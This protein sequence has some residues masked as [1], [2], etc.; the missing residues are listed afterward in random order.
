M[1]PRLHLL[2]AA[3]LFSTGGAAIKATSLT[4][5]QRA[6]FR[7]A[8]AAAALVVLLPAAR[9]AWPGP[10]ALL[11]AVAYAATMVTFVL[12]NSYGTAASAIFLQSVAPL[13]LLAL[14]PWLL[15]EPVTRRDLAFMAA[16]ACGLALLLTGQEAPTRTAPDPAL[17]TACGIGSS[18]GWALTVLGLRWLA[19]AEG[20]DAPTAHA[21]VLGNVV[22]CVACLPW[23]LP[24]AE[25]TAADWAVIVYLGVFQ[26]GVAYALLA[27]GLAHVPALEASLLLLLEPVLNPLWA[28]LAHG[29]RPSALTLAAG[30]VILSATAVKVLADSL[31]AAG[32]A[33][34]GSR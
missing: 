5:F 6:S 21:I 28:W 23:A 24:V 20:D 2:A 27:R 30:A 16:L 29:E 34:A 31:T 18:I 12:A 19:R 33:R 11:V 14:S 4:A 15:R 9:R 3:A 10:R 17:G 1:Q 25:S 8:V 7:S 26:I 22:A 13:Y 32:R